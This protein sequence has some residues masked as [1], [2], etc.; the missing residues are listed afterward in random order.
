[1]RAVLDVLARRIDPTRKGRRLEGSVTINGVPV[2]SRGA[3]RTAYVQQEDQLVGVLTVIETLYVAA[4][5]AGAPRARAEELVRE[6]GLSSARDTRVGTIFQKGISGGQKRRLS[7]AVELVARPRVCLLD[8]PTSG[9]DSASALAVVDQLRAAAKAV[10]TC[11]HCERMAIACTLHQPSSAVWACI[12]EACFLAAGRLIY[13]GPAGEELLAFFAKA[14]H[15]VPAYT[16]IAEFALGLINEDFPG[17]ADVDDLA[18]AF[19]AEDTRP[20]AVESA[21]SAKQRAAGEAS[22]SS[23]AAVR[24]E[25]RAPLARRFATLV[26]RDARELARDVGIVAVRFA[27]YTMLSALIALMYANLGDQKKDT[28]VSAR[29]SVLFYVAAFMVFMSVAVLPFF[30]LQRAVFTKERCN[31]AYD[32]P[33][34][35]AAKFVVSVP[36]VLLIAGVS[37]V[38]IVFPTGL[39]GF[40][41]YFLDLFVSLLVAEGFMALMAACVPHFIVGIALAAGVFG[42]FMLC[43]GFFRVKSDIPEYLQWAYHLAFHTYTFRIFMHNE[44][45][46]I[47]DFDG[48]QFHDGHDVLRFY[49]MNNV[50]VRWD[51]LVLLAWVVFFQLAFGLVL[52]VFHTGRR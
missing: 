33:E 11:E 14:G 26:A 9:L 25:A 7:I 21:A 32:V 51:F 8:E 35:V 31:G 39:N 3:P 23:D 12:D 30:V 42:F 1:M 47:H 13:F 50:T 17:H 16:N 6:F 10:G 34:Y 4:A 46:R 19:A 27:M 41:I 22:S 36:G 29:V 38:M 28:D 40:G 49:D 48:P 45:N 24:G 37:S 15:P 43:E 2:G 20:P 52:H 44:F 18:K 5:F